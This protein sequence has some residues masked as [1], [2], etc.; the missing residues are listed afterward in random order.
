MEFTLK[1]INRYYIK[2]HSLLCDS[3]QKNPVEVVREICGLNAQSARAPYLS[4]WGRIEGFKKSE[5]SKALYED[6]LLIKTWL[7][8]GTVHIVPVQDFT[9]YQKALHGY[10]V[11]RLR[12]YLKGVSFGLKANERVKLHQS[13][14]DELRDASLTKRELLSKVEHLMR[15][16]RRKEQKIIMFRAIWE[17]SHQGLIC[18]GKPTGPW[19]HFKENRFT[20]VENW[21]SGKEPEGI[22]EAEAKRI[23]LEKYLHSYGPASIQDFAYWTGFRVTDARKILDE[24]KD[25]IVS[26]KINDAKGSFLMLKEDVDVLNKI[27][28]DMRSVRFLPEFDSIVMGHKDKSRILNERYRKKVFLPLASVAPTILQGGRVIGIWNYKFIDK[29]LTLSP[30]RSLGTEEIRKIKR[31]SSQLKQ[32]LESPD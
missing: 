31:E 21:L 26:V 10:L 5:L 17:L 14:L 29:S 32:F 1:Q 22:N 24:V 9:I 13:I 3:H 4:L 25:R 12:R 8:R 2:S 11:E 30:F 19:Y 7:L 6:K 20:S 27:D 18:H 16:Y 28:K 15:D 23:L